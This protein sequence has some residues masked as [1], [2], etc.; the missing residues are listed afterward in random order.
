[1][2]QPAMVTRARN[3]LM[4]LEA[5]GGRQ[6]CCNVET[7]IWVRIGLVRVTGVRHTWNGWTGQ[8]SG[9]KTKGRLVHQYAGRTCLRWQG[10]G[11]AIIFVNPLPGEGKLTETNEERTVIRKHR[12]I[13][14][15]W[16]STLKKKGHALQDVSNFLLLQPFSA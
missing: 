13:I 16:L 9:G 14:S 6:G 7:R 12:K 3:R 5:D 11:G 15:K 8:R 4:Y 2:L 1:M 10:G